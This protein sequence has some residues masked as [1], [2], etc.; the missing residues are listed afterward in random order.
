MLMSLPRYLVHIQRVKHS[1]HYERDILHYN[2][3]AY[4]SDG[5]EVEEGSEAVDADVSPSNPF[6]D[7]HLESKQAIFF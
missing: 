1:H 5:Y 3:P 6:G 7:V 2:P 4:D